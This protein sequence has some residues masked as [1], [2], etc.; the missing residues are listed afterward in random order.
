MTTKTEELDGAVLTWRQTIL[1][2][3]SP[4]TQPRPLRTH[5]SAGQAIV[6]KFR[7]GKNVRR[8]WGLTV[9]FCFRP[10]ESKKTERQRSKTDSRQGAS[11]KVSSYETQNWTAHY[12]YDHRRARRPRWPPGA[13]APPPLGRII[14]TWPRFCVEYAGT[15]QCA[16]STTAATAASPARLSSGELEKGQYFGLLILRINIEKVKFFPYGSLKNENKIGLPFD[17]HFCNNFSNLNELT[18]YESP[19]C[20]CSV[21][22]WK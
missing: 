11:S 14:Q 19:T 1:I 9:M 22:I 12:S 18:S 10:P 17:A 13:R 20:S 8:K 2:L 15:A 7:R 6:V 16:T 21:G 3:T 4:T 5:S